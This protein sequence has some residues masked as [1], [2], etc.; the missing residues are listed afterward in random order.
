MTTLARRGVDTEVVSPAMD[1]RFFAYMFGRGAPPP[2]NTFRWCTG[3][4]KI[5]PMQR[6]MEHRAVALRLGQMCWDGRQDKAVYREFG[7]EKP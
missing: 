4:L 7:R 6:A 1:D 5:E 3:Q 2:S